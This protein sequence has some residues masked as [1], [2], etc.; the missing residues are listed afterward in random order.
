MKRYLRLFFMAAG[1]STRY[2]ENKLLVDIA[3]KQMFRYVLEHLIRYRDEH[4]DDCEVWVISSYADIHEMVMDHDLNYIA[5]NRPED[6][7]SRTIRLAMTKAGSRAEEAAVFF[8]ADQPFLTYETVEGFLNQVIVEEKGIVSAKSLLGQ[9][10]PVSFDKKYYEELSKLTGDQGGRVVS[11][12][13][14]DDTVWYMTSV[15]EMQ[16]IDEPGTVVPKL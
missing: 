9:G 4:P 2:G 8:T 12:R 1:D 16:D 7:I 11:V 5:N 10:N 6:G 13:H 14:A 3:G 15:E